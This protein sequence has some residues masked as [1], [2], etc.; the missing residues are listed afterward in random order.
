MLRSALRR[1]HINEPG[2]V[3]PEFSTLHLMVEETSL[4][5]RTT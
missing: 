5:T 2:E 3:D 4:A 1:G